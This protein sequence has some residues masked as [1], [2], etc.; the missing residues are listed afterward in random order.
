MKA[1]NTHDSLETA[2]A[3]VHQALFPERLNTI[4]ESVFS[5][6]WAGASYQEIANTLGYDAIYIRGIGSRLWKQLSGI[7]GEKVTKSNFQVIIRQ[8]LFEQST[9]ANSHTPPLD[10]S[11]ELEKVCL[12]ASCKADTNQDEFYIQRPPIEKRCYEAIVQQGALI[13]IKAP[14]QMGK[15]LLMTKILLCA[16]RH[17][18]HT[19]VVSLRLADVNIFSDL[20]RFLQWFCAV[21]CDQLNISIDLDQQW[22]PIFGSSYNCTQFFSRALLTQ[23]NDPVV[24][25]LDDVD[26]LFDHPE[27]ASD[28]LGLIR[29]WCEK[30]KHSVAKSDAWHLLKLMV[31]HSTEVYIPLHQHQSPFNVGL[32]VELPDFTAEQV[33]SLATRYGVSWTESDVASIMALVGGKPNLVRLTLDWVL[34]NSTPVREILDHATAPTGIFH[35]HLRQQFRRI[36]K[37]PDLVPLLQEVMTK[38]QPVS[39]SAVQGFQLESLGLVKL[40]GQ[41]AA[42]SCALYRQYFDVLLRNE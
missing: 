33:L 41:N 23:I 20:D 13:R 26:V 16:Q 36:Q 17:R 2:L 24:I 30:A 22:K 12:S 18:H 9:A 10:S 3:F 39:L 6:C 8:Y 37:Y 4:Q 5:Q 38:D 31:I 21:V 15:T 34:E 25:A 32:S 40:H 7:F 14:K 28:F 1:D 42:P 19:V 29:A 35:E 11:S 27:I